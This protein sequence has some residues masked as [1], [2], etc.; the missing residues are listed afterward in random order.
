MAPIAS[1]SDPGASTPPA[2]LAFTVCAWA[3]FAV[4]VVGLAG[5]LFLSLGMHLKAC[6]LCFYQRTFV[7]SLGAVLGMGLL[8]G[9]RPNHLA[10]LALPLAFAGLGVALF[11]VRLE[12]TGKLECPRGV[13]G[14]GTAPKQSLA[15]FVLLSVLLLGSAL[16]GEPA[17]GGKWAALFGGVLLGALLA[18]ASYTSNPPPPP[19]PTKPYPGP[20][21]I[22]RP[23]YRSGDNQ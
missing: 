15:T 9:V 21:E 17:G 1:S 4:A 2:P 8:T 14:L 23:P 19:V 13:L 22:C 3:A 5:S 11:H 12:A 7:M 18:L 20:P 6:P 10:L 16:S